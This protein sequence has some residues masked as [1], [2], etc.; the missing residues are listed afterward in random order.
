MTDWKEQKE[1]FV[2]GHD[3]TTPFE[4]ILIAS[5]VP[6]G[7]Y[8]YTAMHKTVITEVVVWIVPM[9]VCQ[10]DYLYPFGILWLFLQLAA[11]F[12][13]KRVSMTPSSSLDHDVPLNTQHATI[14]IFRSGL[15]YLTIIAILAV[16]FRLFPRRFCKT[17]VAGYSLM[18]LG[19]ASFVVA[20]GLVSPKAR[21]VAHRSPATIAWKRI[22]PLVFMG[23]LRLLTHKGLEYPE[24]ATEYGVHWNFF[25]TLAFLATVA[26]WIPGPTCWIPIAAMAC[27]QSALSEY[28]LQEWVENAPRTCAQGDLCCWELF[29]ANREGILGC[30]GYTSLYLISEFLA[31][32]FF[33]G[34]K[35]LLQV[36]GALGLAWGIMTGMDVPVSRRTTNAS[37]CVWTLF[38]CFVQLTCIDYVSSRSKLSMPKLINLI[39]RNG[40]VT[41]VVANI[42][43]GVINLSVNSLEV[44][45]GPAFFILVVYMNVVM[46]IVF[47]VD[48]FMDTIGA[49]TNKRKLE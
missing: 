48:R 28:F 45:D 32:H 31:H 30:I 42:M 7:W 39:N 36:T 6:A 1:A 46:M 4:L 5:T 10:S 8:C 37:F 47:V 12:F 9:I 35:R 26:P 23:M 34:E 16:D 41:F 11:A 15:L 44:D 49:R 22:L 18:D 13:I 33:W 29:V 38:V 20:A 19:A 2:S 3:G 40:L 25:W 24:H 14:T 43:T 17:E 27:Y 21:H